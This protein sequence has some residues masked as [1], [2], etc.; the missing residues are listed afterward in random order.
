MTIWFREHPS[1]WDI[2][3]FQNTLKSAVTNAVN[4]IDDKV[5]EKHETVAYVEIYRENN[6]MH[7]YSYWRI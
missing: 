2:C 5:K 6:S 7:I 1:K 4:A 3:G